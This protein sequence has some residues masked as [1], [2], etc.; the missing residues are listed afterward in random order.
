MPLW[1]NK[2][3]KTGSWLVQ[4]QKSA[5]IGETPQYYVERDLLNDQNH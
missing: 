5:A 1:Y 2:I 4:I 3:D